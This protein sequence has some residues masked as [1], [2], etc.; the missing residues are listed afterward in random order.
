M[1]EQVWVAELML[2]DMDPAIFVPV[3]KKRDKTTRKTYYGINSLHT[4][5][6]RRFLTTSES[7]ARPSQARFGAER[8]C[9]DLRLEL[10]RNLSS[11]MATSNR[12][13]RSPL[14]TVGLCGR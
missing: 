13:Q 9:T 8:G 1:L 3:F 2:A 14:F 11:A 12:P 7:R 10:Q 4:S 5:I 6:L